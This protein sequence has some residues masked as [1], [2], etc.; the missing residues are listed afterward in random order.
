MPIPRYMTIYR[1]PNST[2][3]LLYSVLCLDPKTLAEVKE[4][5]TVT[6]IFVPCSWHTMDATAYKT[7]FPNAK[8]LAPRVALE[9]LKTKI[10]GEIIAAEDVFPVWKEKGVSKSNSGGAMERSVQL[11]YA[12]G[13][14]PEFD[15]CELVLALSTP[16]AEST[17]LTQR[18]PTTT[19]IRHAVVIND[20]FHEDLKVTLI[21]R[22]LMLDDLARFRK[23]LKDFIANVVVGENVEVVIVSHGTPVVGKEQALR[24][25]NA[26]LMSI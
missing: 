15:E 4:L 25:L 6:H 18:K 1:P 7:E 10:D 19:D 26:A 14:S 17:N 23:W 20:M 16:A 21:S 3:L 11:I 13:C 2:S 24:K 9:G 22:I 12:D 8:L 5:G